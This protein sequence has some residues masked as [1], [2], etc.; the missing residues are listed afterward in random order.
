MVTSGGSGRSSNHFLIDSDN[1]NSTTQCRF[2]SG[3]CKISDST[4]KIHGGGAA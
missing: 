3:G 2:V 4:D 1:V